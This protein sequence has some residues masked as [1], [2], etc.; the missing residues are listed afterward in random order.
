MEMT[1]GVV[2]LE[3]LVVLTNLEPL[4]VV[5]LLLVLLKLSS[6]CVLPASSGS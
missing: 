2:A 3:A 5:L 1:A 4:V 6:G